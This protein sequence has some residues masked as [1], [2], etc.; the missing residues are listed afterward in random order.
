MENMETGKVF[1]EVDNKVDFPALEEKVL[2][3]WESEH[4][5]EKSLKA[6]AGNQRYVIFEGP[7]TANGLP[8]V[9][10]V[11]ARVFKDIFPRYKT[12]KGYYVPRRG[13]WDCHGLPVELQIEKQIGVKEKQDIE[14]YGVA[15]FNALCR[16]SVKRYVSEWEEMTKRIAYWVDDDDAYWTMSSGYVESVWW[17]LKKLW[18]EGLLY[19]GY[20]VVPYCPRC[21][22]PLSSHEVAQGYQDVEE[23]SVYVKFELQNEPGTYLLAWT[24]TPWTLPGNVAL[25]VHPALKYVLVQQGQDKLIL[26]RALLDRALHGD[27]TE[28]REMS[29]SELVGAKYKPLYTFV[30]P[31]KPAHYVIA[32]DYVTASDGTG[33]VH[34]A[35]AFGEDDLRVGE[36]SNLPVVQPVDLAGR[37][38]PEVT[39]WAGLTVKEA[40]PQIIAELRQRGLLYRTEKILHSYPFC[41]RCDTALIYYARS[42]WFIRITDVRDRMVKN[43]KHINWYPE[44]VKEGR[45]G[46]WL[47]NAQDWALSRERYWGTPLPVWECEKCGAR[48]CVGSFAELGQRSGSPLPVDFDPHRPFVD[49][50]S[51]GCEKC[52]GT[53]KRVTDVIDV[54]FDS[55]SMPVGQ[56]HYPFE[57]V[58]EFKASFPA[59]FICE[60]MD[61]T[62]GWFYSL[63]A[64]ATLLFD[65]P[66]FKNVISLGLLLGESGDRMSKSRGNVVDPWAV[67]NKHGADGLRWYLL[68]ASPPGNARRFSL[69]LV[70]EAVRRFLL[71][72]WNTYSFFVV[73]ANIDGFNPRKQQIPVAERGTLDRWIISELNK[74]TMD[75]DMLLEDYDVSAAGRALEAF[76]DD[77]SNWYVRRSRRRFWKSENDNDKAAAYLTLYE[78]LTTVAKL[79]APFTPFIADEMYSNLVRSVESSAAESIHL[80]TFPVSDPTLIDEDLN[81]EMHAAMRVVGLGRA[82]RNKTALKVRQP[83][84][85]VLVKARDAGEWSGLKRLEQAILEELNVK[86][87]RRIDSAAE[88]YDYSVKPNLKLVGPKYGKLMPKIQQALTSG[89][90]KKMGQQAASGLPV[91]IQVDGQTIVLLTE[92][93]LVESSVKPGLAAAEDGGYVVALDTTV[94][95]ELEQEGIVRDLVRYIQ[96]MRKSAGFN[97]EDT[98]ITYYEADGQIREAI[99]RWDPYLKGETLSKD[100]VAG[101]PPAEAYREKVDVA[102]QEVEL[103]VV[104]SAR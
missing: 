24:T 83:L 76:V 82:V 93:L 19:K 95:K 43:N 27:Y 55:G 54:W 60:A 94:T 98:I 21:G 89:D 5:F 59:D 85:E 14:T 33:I 15:K 2:R 13:G 103:A 29:A 72:L 100:L 50:I 84:R 26:A 99:E 69:D 17:I 40:D 65:E 56:W 71:T 16:D 68:T 28:I 87:M 12:M 101:E 25:A 53:M 77:L 49:E 42:S 6:T 23:T 66:A 67:I 34:I 63:H 30:K 90:T 81:L 1:R 86:Q 35:P 79:L 48:E 74:L 47:E 46:N 37:F 78:C 70:G 73:Y 44:T 3:F 58:D 57:H 75:V 102:G 22:T 45:F 9:H 38:T 92:E 51:F 11:L 8:G 96:S 104:K 91:E 36:E 62:R 18:D 97:I 31:D 39:P 61:Q 80:T 52:G 7:P 32:A 64:I 41:W 88:V 10:H 4:I 20:K